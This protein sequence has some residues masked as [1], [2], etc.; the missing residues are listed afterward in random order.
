[1][2]G[3]CFFFSLSIVIS[4]RFASG[5]VTVPQWLDAHSL[6]AIPRWLRTPVQYIDDVMKR[7][8]QPNKDP[9]GIGKW[10]LVCRRWRARHRLSSV[11]FWTLNSIDEWLASM[12]SLA[13][14]PVTTADGRHF[15]A[16]DDCARARAHATHKN[17]KN[18]HTKNQDISIYE[19]FLPSFFTCPVSTYIYS[20]IHTHCDCL[21]ARQDCVPFDF[22]TDFLWAIF[23]S[24]V[25]RKKTFAIASHKRRLIFI[26]ALRDG[27]VAIIR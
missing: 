13:R 17:K 18:R 26:G 11:E 2:Q 3:Y 19:F 14:A 22:F 21:T 5:C 6:R 15:M 7:N 27:C 23:E 9:Y 1:M 8:N 25:A 24:V 4:I 10:H 16:N 20:Y 12:I